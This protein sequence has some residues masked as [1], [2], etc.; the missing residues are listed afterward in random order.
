MQE[1]K[2]ERDRDKFDLKEELKKFETEEQKEE[3]LRLEKEQKRKNLLKDIMEKASQGLGNEEQLNEQFINEQGEKRKLRH[4]EK[5]TEK[6]KEIGRKKDNKLEQKI[7][8]LKKEIKK[9]EYQERE[10]NENLE[11]I[12]LLQ[13]KQNELGGLEEFN[14]LNPKEQNKIDTDLRYKAQHKIYKVSDKIEENKEKLKD[15]QKQKKSQKLLELSQTPYIP[16]QSQQEISPHLYPDIPEEEILAQQ[17]LLSQY[18]PQMPPF[19]SGQPL[20]EESMT[21][22][23]EEDYLQNLQQSQQIQR[24]FT[25]QQQLPSTSPPIPS[26]LF[27]QTQQQQI[28]QPTSG[29]ASLQGQPIQPKTSAYI[30]SLQPTIKPLTTANVEIPKEEELNYLKEIE[31]LDKV[32]NN[33]L[34]LYIQKKGLTEDDKKELSYT[35]GKNKLMRLSNPEIYHQFI[36]NVNSDFKELGIKP[37][38]ELPI[39]KTREL[40]NNRLVERNKSPV[41]TIKGKQQLL[42]ILDFYDKNYLNERLDFYLSDKPK[43]ELRIHRKDIQKFIK[44]EKINNLNL[45]KLIQEMDQIQNQSSYINLFGANIQ[46]KLD[47][48]DIREKNEKI[49]LL[50]QEKIIHDNNIRAINESTTLSPEQKQKS[51]ND[52]DDRFNKTNVKINS[53]INPIFTKE[54]G[55]ILDPYLNEKKNLKDI[56]DNV[57]ALKDSLKN[58]DITDLEFEIKMNQNIKKL[59]NIP[60]SDRI[61]DNFDKIRNRMLIDIDIVNDL[62]ERIETFAEYNKFNPN[63]KLLKKIA[64]EAKQKLVNGDIDLGELYHEL[65]R[66]GIVRD[67]LEFNPEEEKLISHKE[68]RSELVPRKFINETEAQKLAKQYGILYI[69]GFALNNKTDLMGKKNS[70]PLDNTQLNTVYTSMRQELEKGIDFLSVK[71][72]KS[73]LFDAKAIADLVNEKI[74]ALEEKGI[75]LDSSMYKEI[76][77]IDE[78]ND[79]KTNKQAAEAIRKRLQNILKTIKSL[80][81]KNKGIDAY[82]LKSNYDTFINSLIYEPQ[83]RHKLTK[84]QKIKAYKPIPSEIVPQTK[85]EGIKNAKYIEGLKY[86]SQAMK[87]EP[88]L[89]KTYYS[90]NVIEYTVQTDDDLLNMRKELYSKKG[91]LYIIDDRTGRFFEIP[92]DKTVKGKSYIFVEEN[93]KPSEGGRLIKIKEIPKNQKA[94]SNVLNREKAYYDKIH[95]MKGNKNHHLIGSHA[96]YPVLNQIYEQQ[97]LYEPY[98]FMKHGYDK[99]PYL[100]HRLPMLPHFQGY[101]YRHQLKR[102]MRGGSWKGIKNYLKEAAK[103]T[104]NYLKNKYT[105]N[106]KDLANQSKQEFNKYINRNKRYVNNIVQS[107]QQFYKKPSLKSFLNAYGETTGNLGNIALAPTISTARELAN[108]SEF[109]D[110]SPGLNV[111]KAITE[112][113]VP[114]LAVADASAKGV[115]ALDNKQYL[116]AAI[117]GIDAILG[118]NQLPGDFDIA[119]KLLNTGLKGVEY[120]N[121][122]K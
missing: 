101:D 38:P 77:K 81:E 48:I 32:T 44:N 67:T 90:D 28:Q 46:G 24:P 74:D 30:S 56:K 94:R 16:L 53:D 54:R 119:A 41:E 3:R 120:L 40:I 14:K 65:S 86:A 104:G 91:T 96:Y 62:L 112:F 27:Q 57:D 98:E 21:K 29:I 97:E 33:F 37:L 26:D 49:Q 19:S 108:V 72:T 75:F 2:K 12:R 7:Q 63:A 50:N 5:Y 15:L 93:E 68:E 13:E 52:E 58:G 83:T 47:A 69:P 45:E 55:L 80:A 36:S 6:Y 106:A 18:Q 4:S 61:A 42:E 107:N 95:R 22:E 105:E 17:Q 109:A 71:L 73:N 117:N 25:P 87:H 114:P 84:F 99:L 92:I 70:Y 11:Y 35:V 43:S 78:N 100:V 31:N 103:E 59:L 110:K 88:K 102:K 79:Y 34:D 82:D 23:E 1:E 115:K 122:S 76:G 121:E 39:Q 9:E 64:I 111:A 85:E 20:Q 60:G 66:Q 51:I 118:T 116:N 10:H 113:L 8:S 89:R